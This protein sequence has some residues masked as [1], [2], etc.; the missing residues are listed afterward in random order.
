MDVRSGK[1]HF[2]VPEPAVLKIIDISGREIL[3][4]RVSGYG[5]VSIPPVKSGVYIA[6][7]FLNDNVFAKK[8][9]VVK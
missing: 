1:I 7:V 6:F 3:R 8:F 5:R 9:V 2:F 4:K